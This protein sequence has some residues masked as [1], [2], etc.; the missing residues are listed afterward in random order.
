MS[1]ISGFVTQKKVLSLW[2]Q[3]R[4]KD[5]CQSLVPPPG[6]PQAGWAETK[7]NPSRQNLCAGQAEQGIHLTDCTESIKGERDVV[8]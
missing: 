3:K 8:Y 6:Q 5:Q 4:G 2:S 7:D 1:T